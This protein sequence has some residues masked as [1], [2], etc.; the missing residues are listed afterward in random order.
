MPGLEGLAEVAR[1]GVEWF[2]LEAP[3]WALILAGVLLLGAVAYLV[4]S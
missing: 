2:V 1:A 3:R 4:L